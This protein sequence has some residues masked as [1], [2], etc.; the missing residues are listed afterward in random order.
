MLALD[1]CR[2][3][4]A[5]GLDLI[6]VATGGGALEGDF[7][8]SGVEA[9]SLER[10]LPLD[11]HVVAS[12]RK[13][14]TK[15]KI[16]VVH[17]HQAVEGLHAYLASRGTGAKLVL[18]FHG[19]IADAKNRLALKFL[20]PRTA[21]NV[22]VSHEFSAWLA[23][24]ENFP[25]ARDFHVI[26]NGVD[27]KRLTPSGK[28]LKSELGLPKNTMLFGMIGNFYPA[29]LKDQFTACRALPDVFRRIRNAHFVFAGALEANSD[30]E[31]C[32]TF[33]CENKIADR[34]HFL[35]ARADIA[36]ILKALDVFVLSTRHESFGIAAAEAM[37][38][39]TPCVLS[40]IEPLLEVARGGEFAEIFRTGDARDLS[41]KLIVL[42]ESFE[43]RNDLAKRAFGYAAANFSIE[44]HIENL[45]RLYKIVEV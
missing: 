23:E 39:K 8:D 45:K 5:G 21:A 7:M 42:G 4:R 9:I 16:K 32:A 37:L 15:R 35:G 44:R 17:A 34:V 24:R 13:I 1:V 18:S 41:E 28:E 30:Y 22:T 29:P 38:T 3:A 19:P 6:F 11:P 25:A 43:L 12:L 31:K 27:R 26:Y 33:C 20:I 2:N 14:I 40:D 36:D 10:R